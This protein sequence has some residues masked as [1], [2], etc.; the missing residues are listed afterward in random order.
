MYF[1]RGDH[2]SPF[3]FAHLPPLC[4]FLRLLPSSSL[5]RDGT[6]CR[7]DGLRAA[8]DRHY[9]H[10]HT[11]HRRMVLLPFIRF[12]YGALRHRPLLY[13]N[14]SFTTFRRGDHWSPFYFAHLPHL[15]R[16]TTAPLKGYLIC[17]S[18]SRGGTQCRS[19]GLRAADDRH[20][21][22]SH[23]GHRRTVLLPFVRFTYGALRHRPLLFLNTS[24]TTFRRGDQWSPF[25]FAH[26]PHLCRFT[27]APLKWHTAVAILHINF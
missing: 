1:R 7:S 11:G 19:G 21:S 14:T 17:L 2:W 26:L 3:Y 6:Q 18:L 4:L 23:T 27:T 25:Y 13:L 15:C 22:H 16:F 12:T 10:S 5:R 20:Y 9:S 24:F 8:D